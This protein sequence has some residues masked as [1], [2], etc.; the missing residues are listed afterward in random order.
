MQTVT[1]PGVLAGKGIVITRPALQADSICHLLLEHNAVPIAFPTLLIQPV[2]DPALAK[3]RLRELEQYDLLL[4]ISVNA[5]EQALALLSQDLPQD[6]PLGLPKRP[7]LAA[8]GKATARALCHAGRVPDFLPAQ[9]NDSEALLALPALH[10]VKGWRVLIVRGVG[11][12]ETLAETLR[13]RGARVEYAEVYQRTIPKADPQS[14]IARWRQGEIH[15]V[16]ATS[17]ETL[18][19]L[20]DMVGTDGRADLL[21]TRLVVVSPRAAVLARQLG[22]RQPAQVAAEAGDQALLDALLRCFGQSPKP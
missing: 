15:A 1:S 6:L 19:N 21:A 5:V 12:R 20:Y 14:L 9:G 8:I 10:Q 7:K 17:N 11:G 13:A 3:A 18:Q 16:T 2:A 22:F 4:F